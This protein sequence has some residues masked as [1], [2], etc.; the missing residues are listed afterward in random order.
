MMDLLVLRWNTFSPGN[1]YHGEE[2]NIYGSQAQSDYPGPADGRPQAKAV[3]QR[4]FGPYLKH[5]MAKAAG[6]LTLAQLMEMGA[7]YLP[8]KTIQETVRELSAL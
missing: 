8:Q 2:V 4:R 5:P 7:V 1:A 6:S 3:L